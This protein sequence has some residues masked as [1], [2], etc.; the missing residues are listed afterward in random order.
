MGPAYNG[1]YFPLEVQGVD[2]GE[3]LYP[4]TPVSITPHPGANA[5]IKTNSL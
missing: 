3:V 4:P 2:G 1:G 5:D